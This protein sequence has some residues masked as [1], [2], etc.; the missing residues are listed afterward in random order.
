MNKQELIK[1]IKDLRDN[2]PDSGRH[3]GVREGLLLAIGMIGQLLEPTEAEPLVIPQFVAD[4]WERD[5]DS[6]TMYGGESIDKKRKVHL[7]SNF[8]DRGLCDHLSK[9][10]DWI[11]EN[12]ST[13]LGLVNGKLYEIEKEKL[14]YVLDKQGKTLL[15]LIGGEVCIS[16]G[17]VLSEGTANKDIYQLTERQIKDYDERFWSFAVEVVE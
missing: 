13:F 12:E 11:D 5:G 10:E 16:G 15:V 8:N 6:V 17:Y 2:Y 14:Y 3:G 4:W 1:N 9:V 7:I